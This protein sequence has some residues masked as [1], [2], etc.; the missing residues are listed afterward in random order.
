MNSSLL[1]GEICAEAKTCALS[2]ES[3]IITDSDLLFYDQMSP[4]FG[5]QKYLIPTPTL[6]PKT[7]MQRRM[8]FRNERYLYEKKCF[9]SGKPLISMY[10]PEDDR[11]I[12]EKKVWYS[13]SWSAFEYGR[14]IDFNRPILQQIAELWH[15]VPMMN[16]Y[17]T[18]D[19]ENCDYTNWFGGGTKASKNCYLCFNGA[20]SEDCM[21]CK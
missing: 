21:F 15:N 16:L 1:P 19:S 4:V 2:G 10:H 17:S 7:R 14:K 6:S 9:F 20:V 18:G 12:C 11:K 8:A 5:G 13:D 3:F